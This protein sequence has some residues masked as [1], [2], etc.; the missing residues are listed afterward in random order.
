MAM[1]KEKY[2]VLMID[3]SEDD[4]LFLRRAILRN[5]RL[6]LVGEVTDG[7]AAV[8][9]LSGNSV[10]HD[11]DKH[12]FPDAVLLDLKMPRMT[13]LE[14]LEWLQGRSFKNLFVAIVSGSFL[15]EDVAQSMALGANAY[16]K[17]N[18]LR[19]EQA[20]MLE[21]IIKLLDAHNKDKF[22]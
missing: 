18:A 7:E 9:Y 4:R 22:A 19:E 21:E 2:S 3:D 16:F 5:P 14:V 12:P 13:G 15:P 17:K 20:A 6:S 10:F 8:D 1:P 11:R